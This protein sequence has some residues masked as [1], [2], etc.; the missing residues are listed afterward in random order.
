MNGNVEGVALLNELRAAADPEDPARVIDIGSMDGM[1][2]PSGE[3]F[4]HS[5]SKDITGSN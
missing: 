4:C 1:R 3:S 2:T 5:A